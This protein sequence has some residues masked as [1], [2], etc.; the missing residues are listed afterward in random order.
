[1]RRAGRPG[2]EG[3]VER[4]GVAGVL[5]LGGQEDQGLGR[6]PVHLDRR[7]VL[8]HELMPRDRLAVLPPRLGVGDDL[9]QAVLD[10]AQAAGRD[11]QPAADQR[12]HRD[13]EALPLGPEQ[14]GRRDGVVAEHEPHGV[15]RDVAD[16]GLERCRW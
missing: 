11:A 10:D 14:V 1:M 2:A 8:L 16:L 7:D 12:A 5:G 13:R 15:G 4:V 6:Q 9:A 3:R